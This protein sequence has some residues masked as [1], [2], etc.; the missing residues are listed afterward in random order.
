[1]KY[2]AVKK[3]RNPGIYTSWD[4]CLKE[5]KGY[6][7]AKYKSFKN[8]K[9]AENFLKDEKIEDIKVDENSV[10]AYIDG[11]YSQKKKA[12]GLGIFYMTDKDTKEVYQSFDDDYHVYRNV[13]GEVRAS[14][15]AINM[16]IVDKKEII[17]IHFDYQGIESWAV[18][19]W[20]RNNDLT[21]RYYKFF[22]KAKEKI[23]VH[24]IKVKAHS[25]DK[26]NDKA[27]ELAKKSLGIKT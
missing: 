27:D 7:G 12:Y 3:G 8:K 6:K 16:A 23:K 9:D 15:E 22:Q 13:A 5:V 2:Y 24:F 14:V 11:S 1:M 21:K 18:G 20:K 25:N 19:E 26:Y 4:L 17:Y 10:I